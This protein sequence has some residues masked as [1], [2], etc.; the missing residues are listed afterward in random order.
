LKT[1]TNP[2]APTS[3]TCA[4][5]ACNSLAPQ[6][7]RQLLLPL[8]LARQPLRQKSCSTGFSAKIISKTKCLYESCN[9]LCKNETITDCFRLNCLER[10]NLMGFGSNAGDLCLLYNY[11]D[12]S[13]Y[14][15]WIATSD[16]GRH[17][18][19]AWN[20]RYP[21][22][23]KIEQ[24]SKSVIR[25]LRTQIP[26]LMRDQATIGKIYDGGDAQDLLQHFAS[27]FDRQVT[28]QVVGRQIED[29][30]RNQYPAKFFCDD[31][32]R[33]RS[34]VR[35]S[36]TT[37]SADMMSDMIMNLLL[38]YLVCFQILWFSHDSAFLYLSNLGHEWG[39]IRSETTS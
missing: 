1:A 25:V 10:M 11:S 7:D 4:R 12:N 17:D 23:V 14:G 32:H 26:T 36:L 31:G 24:A 16:G 13:L 38:Q 21:N 29:D 39:R 22:Q 2:P 9:F 19:T 18:A 30:Y 3:T 28:N 27:V 35:K 15:V 37:G 33:V 20:G 5:A 34:P 6:K 8:R